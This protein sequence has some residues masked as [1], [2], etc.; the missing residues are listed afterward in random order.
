MQYWIDSHFH[1]QWL[2]KTED[3]QDTSLAF[4]T[5][6]GQLERGLMVSV[7][8]HDR[9]LLEALAQ[10]HKHLQWSLGV[11][12]CYVEN[13]NIDTL[14]EQL[15]RNPHY[16]ALGETGLDRYHSDDS[17]LMRQQQACF[18]VHMECARALQK[19][20]IVH[21]R[22][23]GEETLAVL[24]R[25]PGVRG[26]IHCFTESLEFAKAVFDLGWMISLSGILTFPK[27]QYLRDIV[28]Y[29]PLDRLL[30]ETDAPYLA[31]KPFR[32]KTNQPHYVQYVGQQISQLK[33]L[34]LDFCQRTISQNYESFLHINRQ[35]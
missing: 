15:L 31:P 16:H 28:T 11:H 7:Q 4:E 34:P 19:P 3:G 22:N 1:P 17:I 30:I 20:L 33:G 5:S 18:E 10:K 21:T 13:Q 32:G 2:L 24:S 14:I 35:V 8:L 25:Y 9:L 29:A 23:A 27:A 26:V 6:I 12:P